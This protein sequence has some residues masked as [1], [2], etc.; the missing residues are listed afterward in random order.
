MPKWGIDM[1]EGRVA[2]WLAAAGAEVGPGLEI[3]E[4]ESEKTVGAV[5]APAAGVLH[6]VAGP[7]D[8]L[9]VGGLLGVIAPA[10]MAADELETFVRG[11]RVAPAG[12]SETVERDQTVEVPGHALRLVSLGAGDPPVLL[13]HGFGGDLR[14]WG[15]VQAAL[16]RAQ[17]V[18]SVD[19]PAHGGSTTALA[20]AEPR[21]F[22]DLILGLL[23]VL[24]VPRVHLVGHSWG[25]VIAWGVAARE[26][27]RVASLTLLG[28]A[29]PVTP[30]DP[31]YV[32]QFIEAGRRTE[33]KAV[34]QR[35]FADPA[36]VTRDMVEQALRHKRIETV[37]AAWRRIAAAAVAASGTGAAAAA[38]AV[39]IQI[40]TGTEDRICPLGADFVPPAGVSLHRLPGVGHLPQL[41]APAEVASRVATFAAA[42]S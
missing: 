27:A 11:F 21:F 2:Q 28:T 3:V 34:L 36:L 16:A 23:D 6:P 7:G 8:V 37:E 42:H 14:G 30:P 17:R 4:V 13:L 15:P 39:P 18:I 32:R 38:P 41:E 33:L 20:S 5:E 24:A 31:D 19:L 22:E 26:P 1:T 10:A 12:E 40:I 9:P 29:G 35:L 25:G